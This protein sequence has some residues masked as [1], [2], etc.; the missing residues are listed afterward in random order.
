MTLPLTELSH[1]TNNG[2][3]VGSLT[4]NTVRPA[5]G[6]VIIVMADALWGSTS[7]S[8]FSISDTFADTGG[9]AW[10]PFS[11]SP[12]GTT[13][14]STYASVAV[15]W[16][17]TVGT[18]PG[19]GTVTVAGNA[20]V[21]QGTP[22]GFELTVHQITGGTTVAQAKMASASYSATGSIA[23]GTAPAASSLVWAGGWEGGT[24]SPKQSVTNAGFTTED[25]GISGQ[26]CVVTEYIDGSGPQTVSWENL[27]A[28][29]VNVLAIAEVTSSGATGFA[30]TSLSATGEAQ[31][32]DT[33][34]FTS[35]TFIPAPNALL[36]VG[37]I[38][39][40][41][42][43]T[44]TSINISDTLGG[45]QWTYL[46][47][48]GNFGDL[49]QVWYALAPS[50][51]TA[52]AI[53]ITGVGASPEAYW[54]L[55]VDQITTGASG[56]V[57]TVVQNVSS[58]ESTA[59][60]SLTLPSAPAASSMLWAASLVDAAY[61]TATT[62]SGY[63]ALS[64]A[65]GPSGYNEEAWTFIDPGPSCPQT[66]Q[67]TNGACS[68]AGAYVLEI[69]TTP[70]VPPPAQPPLRSV[71]PRQALFRAANWHH[72]PKDRTVRE[73]LMRVA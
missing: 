12:A 68:Y 59:N 15:A 18:S 5:A 67:F 10:Q 71:I 57:P 7:L 34:S 48:Y 17:R 53:T 41:V 56:M 36:V 45:L 23:F 22:T 44:L 30:C 52:G 40:G 49:Q 70:Y 3:A 37:G 1:G 50:V 65:S 51:P 33:S 47:M 73:P 55:A 16:W 19:V 25:V 38:S 61:T 69:N 62:I 58:D 24:T 2:S 8:S 29:Q 28:G 63:S 46:T 32:N 6:S 42:S 35:Q 4:S 14:P 66:S 39:Q 9:G 11:G 27:S 13:L 26:P 20:G 72:L 43:G 64:T 21:C 31:Y 54:V 60:I